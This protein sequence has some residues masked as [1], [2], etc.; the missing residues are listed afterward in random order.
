MET[1]QRP[2]TH[3]KDLFSPAVADKA[4]HLKQPT[5]LTE[6]EQ[7]TKLR[8]PPLV[9][10][11][12]KPDEIIDKYFSSTEKKTF[13]EFLSIYQKTRPD[14]DAYRNKIPDG[15]LDKWVKILKDCRVNGFIRPQVTNGELCWSQIQ[16]F[17]RNYQNADKCTLCPS[18][19]K[20]GDCRG[21]TK[22]KDGQRMFRP[23]WEV[24]R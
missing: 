22:Y 21:T 10:P 2:M 4:Y 20:S 1:T 17:K 14:W 18:S 6:S 16:G 8:L 5:K 11:K 19:D 23:C 3:I 13:T 12:D 15:M 24:S 7:N 9:T